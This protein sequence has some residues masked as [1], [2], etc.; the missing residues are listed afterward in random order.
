MSWNKLSLDSNPESV[1]AFV[2]QNRISD[3]NRFTKN[4]YENIAI[5][6]INFFLQ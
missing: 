5:F 2:K 1:K 4:L 6:Q 3:N